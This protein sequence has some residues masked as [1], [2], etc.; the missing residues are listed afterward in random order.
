MD[1]VFLNPVN[2]DP[3]NYATTMPLRLP[4]PANPAPE[5]SDS[6]SG[7]GSEESGSGSEY[8]T[9]SGSEE[10]SGSDEGEEDEP[11]LKYQRL[12]AR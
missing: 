5:G 4:Q 1:D 10:E 7:S 6:E 3:C 12:G 9:G 2:P 11:K 8:E